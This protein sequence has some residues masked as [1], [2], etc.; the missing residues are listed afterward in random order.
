MDIADI[1]IHVHPKLSADDRSGIERALS[2]RNGVIAVHFFPGH[3]HAL[4]VA[5]NP[6]VIHS[7]DILEQIRQ[8]DKE[9]VMAGL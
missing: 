3:P 4:T 5:Y 9:A 6:K 1:V 8:Q 7:K 2:D